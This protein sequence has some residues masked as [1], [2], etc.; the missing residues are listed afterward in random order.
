[1]EFLIAKEGAEFQ[2]YSANAA[3]LKEFQKRS[4]HCCFWVRE[5][6]SSVW[7]SGFQGLF[8][9]ATGFANFD[10]EYCYVHKPADIIS[11]GGLKVGEND[12]K[13]QRIRIEEQ[14]YALP[15]RSN[16]EKPFGW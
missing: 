13:R 7:R 14:L 16:S 6:Q 1:M 2:K 11:F 3:E 12:A 15:L 10:L 4:S 8:P 5:S 9:L